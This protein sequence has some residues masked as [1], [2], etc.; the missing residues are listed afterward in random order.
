MK[1]RLCD[2]NKGKGKV[3]KQLNDKFPDLDVKVKKCI[4]ICG[5]C[6]KSEK[7]LKPAGKGLPGINEKN[8]SEK[9]QTGF[10]VRRIWENTE[11]PASASASNQPSD[12]ICLAIMSWLSQRTGDTGFQMLLNINAP[13][14]RNTA[15]ES[16]A[17]TISFGSLFISNRSVALFS[18]SSA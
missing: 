15:R 2:K 7:R 4:D 1:I 5:D 11:T 12:T 14:E 17:Q 18:I 10:F 16:S 3:E 8:R 9:H 13:T 6:D